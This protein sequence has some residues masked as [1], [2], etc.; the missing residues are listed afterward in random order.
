VRGIL[1]SVAGS[2]Q[3]PRFCWNVRPTTKTGDITH[4]AASSGG[5]KDKLIAEAD[6]ALYQPKRQGKNR[7]VRA[8]TE[9]ANLFSA[10]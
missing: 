6:S 1:A 5:E 9:A 7:T 10:E 8:P 4:I 2:A 3:K